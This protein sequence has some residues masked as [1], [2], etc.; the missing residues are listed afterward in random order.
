MEDPRLA[1]LQEAIEA[2]GWRWRPGKP[3]PYGTQVLVEDG[4][5]QATLNYYPNRGVPSWAG[6]IRRCAARW[7]NWRS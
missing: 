7:K 2:R 4:R 1:A 5:D 6:A 3:I